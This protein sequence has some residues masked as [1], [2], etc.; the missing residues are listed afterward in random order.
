[1]PRQQA[2][3]R[4][5]QAVPRG[6]NAEGADPPTGRFGRMFECLQPC[7]L[8]PKAI[9]QLVAW[10]GS[11]ANESGGSSIAAGFTY[12]GQFIDHDIT[13]DPTPP[14]S[15]SDPHALINFRTPRLDL[16][17]VYG[18][19]RIVQP[20]LYDWDEPDPKGVRLLT[21][22]DD[23]PRNDQ[24]RAII[25]DARNDEN[26]IIAQLHL[27]FIR[28]HN[29][30]VRHLDGGERSADDLVAEAQMVVRR[31]YQWIVTHEFLPKV[32]GSRVVK[33]VLDGDL[34]FYRCQ[35]EP[36]I[37]VEFSGAAYRF[38]HSMVRSAYGLRAIERRIKK[39]PPSPIFPDLRGFRALDPEHR[40]SWRRFF[41]IDDPLLIQFQPAQAIDTRIADRLFTLPDDGGSLPERNLTRGVALGLPSGQDVAHVMHEKPLNDAELQL[42]SKEPDGKDVFSG[43]VRE[44]LLT[45]APLWYYIL[46][47]AASARGDSGNH[48]GPVGGRIVAEVLVGL[49]K[50][51]PHSYLN[52]DPPWEPHELGVKGNYTMADLIRF[53][54]A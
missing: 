48:L 23:L 11:D 15:H 29:A 42:D 13:F 46:A 22:F 8:S 19:G 33:S 12:L 39:V 7:P 21:G 6:Q 34:R 32:V 38:G 25:G 3:S 47:E 37:P 24:G 51:D 50:A 43:E 53:V 28:F 49:L 10:M 44:E 16:D 36:F 1:M 54:Q 20:F 9:A 30:V 35:D 26:A 41:E 18:S 17:S 52:A 27:L 45:A 40:I 5:G 14:T 31:H 2:G 4:H